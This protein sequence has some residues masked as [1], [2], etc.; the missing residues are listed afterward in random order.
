[1]TSEMEQFKKDRA[2]FQL[3]T[4]I[5]NFIPAAKARLQKDETLSK[6]HPINPEHF[7]KLSL[8][9]DECVADYSLDTLRNYGSH[10]RITCSFHQFLY[11]LKSSVVVLL[12]YSVAHSY[13]ACT[14]SYPSSQVQCSFLQNAPNS[15][16][17]NW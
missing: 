4:K 17:H 14:S 5:R 6:P 3:A 8:K 10:F 2:G 16:C 7:T 13:E 9:L 12:K 1:M 11:C 15:L